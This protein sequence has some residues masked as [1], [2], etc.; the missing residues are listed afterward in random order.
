MIEIL[1]QLNEFQKLVSEFLKLLF[2]WQTVPEPTLAFPGVN[3]KRNQWSK[4]KKPLKSFVDCPSI[5]SFHLVL[6]ILSI[7]S[8][9]FR[10]LLFLVF[11]PSIDSMK[12]YFLLQV[13]LLFCCVPSQV[14]I[15]LNFIFC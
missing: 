15:P 4:I 7:G 11:I 14:L 6:L 8:I 5:D 2:F 1:K 12:L 9:E 3:K 13:L 10:S